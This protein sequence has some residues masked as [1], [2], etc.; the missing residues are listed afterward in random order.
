MPGAGAEPAGVGRSVRPGVLSG[1]LHRSGVLGAVHSEPAV[2][3]A[4]SLGRLCPGGRTGRYYRLAPLCGFREGLPPAV[5]VFGCGQS[6]F[7]LQGLRPGLTASL[8]RNDLGNASGQRSKSKI[9]TC[10]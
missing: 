2:V 10:L 6:M 5:S 9:T 4:M 3:V 1:G 8:P 7:D